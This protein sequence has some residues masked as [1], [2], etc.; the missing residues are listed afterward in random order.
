VSRWQKIV[1][2]AL[3][4]LIAALALLS[5]DDPTMDSPT[6]ASAVVA[7]DDG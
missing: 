4:V 6:P 1:A 7:T 2:A 3:L 5:L